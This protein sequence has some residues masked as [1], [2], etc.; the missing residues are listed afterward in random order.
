MVLS[1]MDAF[2][3]I[4]LP[5]IITE[6]EVEFLFFSVWRIWFLMH[7]LF[8]PYRFYFNFDGIFVLLFNFFCHF[9]LYN[10][11]MFHL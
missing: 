6:I 10:S 1:Y 4:I 11:R 3:L 5:D 8:F 7:N 2:L 9:L